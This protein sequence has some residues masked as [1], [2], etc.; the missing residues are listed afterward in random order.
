MKKHEQSPWGVIASVA[1]QTSPA[2]LT[3]TLQWM[4]LFLT[5]Q[6]ETSHLKS[7]MTVVPESFRSN[8]EFN[9][10]LRK[11][12]QLHATLPWICTIVEPQKLKCVYKRRR[13]TQGPCC[14]VCY[15]GCEDKR[16]LRGR[17]Q[18][19]GSQQGPDKDLPG[20]EKNTSLHWDHFADFVA[21]QQGWRKN[22]KDKIK[23]NMFA[24]K[25]HGNSWQWACKP[26]HLATFFNVFLW[27]DRMGGQI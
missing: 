2:H 23:P 6:H 20:Q 5:L 25:H 15:S 3:W 13:M 7:A 21:G 8:Q 24:G 26:H 12:G 18:T 11:R 9:L 19:I 17:L 22:K 27:S 16:L 1:L 14:K 10:K 4:A